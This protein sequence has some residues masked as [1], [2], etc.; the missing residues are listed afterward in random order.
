[1]TKINFTL[2]KCKTK[3]AYSTKLKQRGKIDL[4]K[5]KHKYQVTLETP[6]LLV[7]K[8]ESIEIIVHGHGELFFKDCSD[9]DFME[10]TAQEIYEIGLEK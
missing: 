3:A 1:M 2:G 8:I 5:I 4:N 6:L 7:I 9:L 10:K